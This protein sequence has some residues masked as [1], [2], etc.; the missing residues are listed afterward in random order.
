MLRLSIYS[1]LYLL[2]IE[3]MSQSLGVSNLNFTAI[4]FEVAN[5]RNRASVCSV[6]LVEVRDG[7]IVQEKYTLVNPH[8]EFDPYC[9]AVHGITPDQVEG[10]PSFPEIWGEIRTMIEGRTLVAHNASFDLSVLR[11]CMETYGLEYPEC[12]YVCSY[13]LSRR[14]WPGLPGYKLN[15]MAAFH[16]LPG[17]RH[18]DALEDARAAAQLLLKCFEAS[19][20]A[21]DCGQLAA[22][23]GYRIGALFP[24][25][26]YE[27][28]T[29]LKGVSKGRKR[30]A[31][32]PDPAAQSSA[33][34]LIPE[35]QV[36][37]GHIFYRK[38]IAFTG[39]LGSL[40]RLDAMQRVVNCGG[41]CSDAVELKT[42]YLV[43]G[44]KEY[45]KLQ[46]GEARSS[47][48]QKA[49]RLAGAGLPIRLISEQQFLELL[50]S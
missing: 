12:T 38:N 36:D 19:E 21:A 3:T 16:H 46:R 9:V 20:D 28:F 22:S 45:L 11:F 27:T 23:R 4:D 10:A 37:A 44:Q 43:V 7:V 50:G 30:Q 5:M 40:T 31:S 41:I 15:Q 39:R 1:K 29:S 14:I 34:V 42:H 2:R 8:D 18:H 26:N 24:G 33:A 49:E 25:G 35:V 6:G 47:Q 48:I 17:F 13:L 32:R